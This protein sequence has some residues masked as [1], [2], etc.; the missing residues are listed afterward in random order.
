[1]IL[2]G[3]QRAG[4]GQLAAHLLNDLDNDHV[5]VLDVRGFVSD[6]LT[7][8]FAEA[9]AIAKGTKCTQYLFSLSLNPPKGAD[10]TEQ[11]FERAA[12]QAEQ[13]LG[14]TGQPHALILHEKEGRRHAHVVWSRIDAEQMKAIN[15]PF[16]KRKL[17]EL[18]KELF[19]EHGWALPDGLRLNGGK[20]PL[21][22][23]LAEYQQ[24]KRVGLD[25]REV[26]DAFRDAWAHSDNLSAFGNAM[27][28]RGYFLAKGD[29]RGL[30]AVD[31]NGEVFNVGKYAGVK[32]KELRQRLGITSDDDIKL[33]SVAERQ[34][35]VRQLMT[36][37]LRGYLQEMRDDQAT[38]LRPLR[39]RNL[40]LREEHRAQRVRLQEKQAE[41]W[42]A[43]SE[44]RA[45]RVRTGIAGL[46]DRL[47]GRARAITRQNEVEA[48]EALRRDRMQRDALAFE[49]R[50]ER[51]ALQ[52]RT[53]RQR[54][55]HIRE[56]QHIH[57]DLMA[58]VRDPTHE[59]PNHRA[60]RGVSIDL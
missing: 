3:S 7:E 39:A 56:R 24:A 19:L 54:A 8:A 1:M 12:D 59:L 49:Q 26:K 53:D 14:L 47:S 36:S 10:A 55:T 6:D 35:E 28:E 22:Y 27:E 34:I 60:K 33:P 20:S 11:D 17:T 58:R 44:A 25:P 21:A 18:S 42:R 40:E 32:A 31:V 30:V 5:T 2:K 23:S 52:L 48:Y 16:F 43:E 13:V 29:Q 50:Q 15:L 45:L 57:R 38:E 46:W 37:K 41:R 4:G 51:Q 9:Q